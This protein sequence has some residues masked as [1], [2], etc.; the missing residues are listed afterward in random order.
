[1]TKEEFMKLKAENVLVFDVRE[2]NEFEAD[3]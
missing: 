2:A 1:M 3:R